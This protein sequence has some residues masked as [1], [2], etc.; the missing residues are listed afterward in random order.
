MKAVAKHAVLTVTL[1]AASFAGAQQS[2]R[3]GAFNRCQFI[4]SNFFWSA[5]D[6]SVTL[7][8]QPLRCTREF[9]RARMTDVYKSAA[10]AA[11]HLD[12]WDGRHRAAPSERQQSF[13]RAVT[14]RR[15][16]FKRLFLR[17][18]CRSQNLCGTHLHPGSSDEDSSLRSSKP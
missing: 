16:V 18:N 11:C 12:G 10:F 13:R 5:P 15:D 17:P 6:F 2:V 7:S 3:I 9:R 8:F 1:L 4:S 14:R